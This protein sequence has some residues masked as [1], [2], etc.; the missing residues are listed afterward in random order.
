LTFGQFFK[1]ETRRC[2]KEEITMMRKKKKTTKEMTITRLTRIEKM[3]RTLELK[4]EAMRRDI[5]MGKQPLSLELTS[6][7]KDM[8]RM[9]D[10]WEYRHHGKKGR[11][12]RLRP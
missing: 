3:V 9:M 7:R 4:L 12:R 5:E 1:Y 10:H 6:V 8:K 11:P 2:P